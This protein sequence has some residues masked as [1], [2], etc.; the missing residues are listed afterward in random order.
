M[1]PSW[2]VDEARENYPD[3]SQQS[4]GLLWILLLCLTGPPLALLQIPPLADPEASR[5]SDLRVLGSQRLQSLSCGAVAR[6]TAS[7]LNFS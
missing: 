1:Q 6:D 7:G 5:L 4:S 3:G 2:N